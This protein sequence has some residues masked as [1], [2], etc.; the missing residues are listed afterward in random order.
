MDMGT[1][2]Q[3][4]N[5]HVFAIHPSHADK[6]HIP[7]MLMIEIHIVICLSKKSFQNNMTILIYTS[8]ICGSRILL[9]CQR[10]FEQPHSSIPHTSNICAI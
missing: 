2:G 5:K 3:S 9:R 7:A 6:R 1:G 10:V 4:E 8:N